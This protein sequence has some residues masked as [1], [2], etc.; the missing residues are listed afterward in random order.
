MRA[1]S[2][3][4]ETPRRLRHGGD[5]HVRLPKQPSMAALCRSAKSFGRSR[6]RSPC[7]S[8]ALASGKPKLVLGPETRA[9]AMPWSPGATW[10]RKERDNGAAI[11]KTIAGVISDMV[12]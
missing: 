7:R 4:V 9:N 6:S 1:Y 3:Q 2:G 8:K 12:F 11:K 5:Q 10:P